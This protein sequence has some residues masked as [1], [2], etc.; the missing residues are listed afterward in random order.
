[1]GL[2]S[3]IA[4]IA[5][6]STDDSSFQQTAEKF[7]RL[8][9]KIVGMATAVGKA[10]T[11]AEDPINH[12]ARKGGDP[13]VNANTDRLHRLEQIRSATSYVKTGLIAIASVGAIFGADKI[14]SG[15]FD[16]GEAMFAVDRQARHMGNATEDL[17]GFQYAIKRIGEEVE[18]ATKALENMYDTYLKVGQGSKLAANLMREM[19]PELQAAAAAGLHLSPTNVFEHTIESLKKIENQSKRVAAA[20]RMFGDDAKSVIGLTNLPDNVSDIIQRP[21]K[22]GVG[23]DSNEIAQLRETARQF[24]DALLKLKAFVTQGAILL[25]PLAETITG[26][27]N[28][29]M[30]GEDMSKL[31][32]SVVAK[33]VAGFMQ[34]WN[35]LMDFLEGFRGVAQLLANGFVKSFAEAGQAMIRGMAAELQ[36]MRPDLP[37]ANKILNPNDAAL[38][39]II[40]NVNRNLAAAKVAPPKPAGKFPDADSSFAHWIGRFANSKIFDPPQGTHATV[41]QQAEMARIKPLFEEANRMIPNMQ[42][43]FEKYTLEMNKLDKM[44]DAGALT[45]NQYGRA[46]NMTAS[47]MESAMQMMAVSL[48]TIARLNTGQA[49]STIA[50]SELERSVKSE[51]PQR[52]LER[53]TQQGV[54]SDIRREKY[55]KEI[56]TASTISRRPLVIPFR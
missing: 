33:I 48:P 49:E 22:M 37:G 42:T 3:K 56:A 16:I 25:A 23:L 38:Q 54:E 31:G 26:F 35:L 45:F 29:Q 30:K 43:P 8:R 41:Q 28:D 40:D 52:R 9:G 13:F 11:G 14:V 44:L 17:V 6:A 39:E 27:I 47:A 12:K 20:Y 19:S 2:I 36:K 32:V 10:W 21:R 34:G 55:L 4:A 1:V 18:P 15:I 50:K 51:N 5:F 24:D 53:L 7:N 46:V